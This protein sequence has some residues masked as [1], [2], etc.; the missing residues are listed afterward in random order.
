MATYSIFIL[1]AIFSP[2]RAGKE[3]KLNMFSPPPPAPQPKKEILGKATILLRG[4]NSLHSKRFQ[5]S[6]C[7]FFCSCPSFLHEPREET[8]ATQARDGKISFG[9][10]IRDF[11]L[12]QILT[13]MLQQCN[14]C[15]RFICSFC[16][17]IPALM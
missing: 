10:R 16:G 7:G 4:W 3:N 17:R 9:W 14:F 2:Y 11:P 15:F 13:T 1:L 8:L 6:Y 12:L 5:S